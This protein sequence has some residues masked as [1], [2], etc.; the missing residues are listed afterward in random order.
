MKLLPGKLILAKIFICFSLVALYCSCSISSFESLS[1]PGAFPLFISFI[2]LI[3]AIGIYRES[4]MKEKRY[5]N[6]ERKEIIKVTKLLF[7]NPIIILTFAS[8]VFIFLMPILGFIV[9]S[10]LFAWFLFVCFDKNDSVNFIIHK[11]KLG[12]LSITITMVIYLLFNN[13]FKV[14]LP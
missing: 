7:P 3:F 13:V 10:F 4:K 9:S 6:R 14:L 2:L 8:I 5:N 11:L 12:I 1:S